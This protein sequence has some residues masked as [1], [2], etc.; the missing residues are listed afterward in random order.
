[1]PLADLLAPTRCLACSSPGPPLCRPCHD[2]LP[3][4]P[5]PRCATCGR[6]VAHPVR[7]CRE[8]TSP[9]PAFA[10]ARAAVRLDGPAAALVRRWKDGGLRR[11][12]EIA[13]ELTL[14]AVARVPA[15]RVTAVPGAGDRVRWRGL[16]GPWQL[17]CGLADAWGLP[18][19]QPLLRR[20]A[21]RAQRGL[22]AAERR[23][24]ARVAF[25]AVGHG[26]P[27]GTVL[28]VDDV[29]TT[30]ATV[31]ACARLLRRAGAARVEVVT[32]ARVVR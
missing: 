4:L 15:D 24:N 5:A 12:G 23:R 10:A 17:A 18:P 3:W 29:F 20:V 14:D 16:D 21:P 25:A 27:G 6:P 13:L 8:C 9:R 31:D 22:S 32:F 26:A 11:A 30:G 19:P 1:M 28:I 7:R 2:R